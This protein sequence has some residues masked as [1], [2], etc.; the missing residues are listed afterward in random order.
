MLKNYENEEFWRIIPAI[1]Q[2]SCSLSTPL[3]SG[4][5]HSSNRNNA[6][7][8]KYPFCPELVFS[9]LSNSP[10][11]T[12]PGYIY[13]AVSG[14]TGFKGL[15][16]LFMAQGLTRCAIT[17][18]PLRHRYRVQQGPLPL[19]WRVKICACPRIPCA[20]Q[21]GLPP[22]PSECMDAHLVHHLC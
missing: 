19:P 3:E 4:M 11:I 7:P 10:E 16:S 8:R 13:R 17:S 6:F 21:Q 20:R 1:A 15:T 5:A 22:H 2:P 12:R 18:R 9:G 14:R